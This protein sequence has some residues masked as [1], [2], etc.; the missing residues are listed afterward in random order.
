MPLIYNVTI[1]PAGKDDC[2]RITWNDAENNRINS[3][4]QVSEITIED[5]MR[6]SRMAKFQL[7]IGQK[8][9]RFLDG[10][11]HT[12]RRA[13]DRTH[14]KG[15]PLQLHLVTCRQTHDWPFELLAD[16]DFLLP[17]RVHLIRNVSSRG[18]ERHEVPQNRLLKLLFMASAALD[19][20][21][22]L[23]F[24][25]EEDAIF[26]ITANLPID[27]EVEDSGSLDGL[28]R[29]LVQEAFDVVHLS[30]HAGITKN[31][32]PYFLMEDETGDKHLVFPYKLWNEALIENPPKVLF[33]SGRCTIGNGN[34]PEGTETLSIARSLVKN[35]NISAVVGWGRAV[36]DEQA[37]Q[38]G[39]VIFYQLSRGK[40]ILEAVQRARYELIT[41]FP[42]MEK[43]AWP[44]LRLFSSGVP[45]NAIV[46]EGQKK[47]PKPKRMKHVYLKNSQV[48]VLT[49]GFVGRRRQL[50][51]ALRTL[52]QDAKKLGILILGT[53]GLGKSCLAGKICERFPHHILIIVH[54]KLNTLTLEPVLEYA[55]TEAQD[56]TGQHI[57][58]QK[59]EMTK[60]IAKLCSSSFK[61]K[62][63]L[64]LLDDFEQNLEGSEKNKPGSLWPEAAELLNALLRHL[65][66]GSTHTQL[67]ITSRYMFSLGPQYPV[68]IEV[69][70]QKVWLTGFRKAQQRK[71]ARALEHISNYPDQALVPRLLAAGHGNPRLMEWIDVLVGEMKD[72]EVKPLL[73]AVKDKQE[74]F[75]RQHLIRVLL[76]REEKELEL[77]LRRFSIFR[78]PV[79]LDG[80]RQVTQKG[81]SSNWEKRLQRGMDLSLIEHDQTR[82]SYQLTPL[83]RAELLPHRKDIAACHEAALAYYKEQSDEVVEL[84]RAMD[85]NDY[86]QITNQ[87]NSID[88]ITGE[89]LIYHA[90][91]CGQEDVAS[92]MGGVL[93]NHLG[94][95]IAAT[96]ALRIG[97][98]ILEEKK[99]ACCTGNDAF[100]LSTIAYIYSFFVDYHN[101]I[102]YSQQALPI[103][104]QVFGAKHP[105]VAISLNSLG[106]AYS[107][108]GKNQKA[109][110][111]YSEAL[112]IVGESN[113]KDRP[114]M[115]LLFN[116][117]GTAH[118]HLGQYRKAIHY[119]TQALRICKKFFT[120]DHNSILRILNNLGTA[121]NDLGDYVEAIDY[122]RQALIIS[123][124]LYDETHPN[125]STLLNNLGSIYIQ[126]GDYS[127]AVGYLE[128]ALAIDR[129]L[130]GESH[131]NVA[132]VLQNLGTCFNA[133]ADYPRA[134][135]YFEHALT[136]WKKAY[137][138]THPR[139]A[140]AMNNLGETWRSRG[141][142]KK[143]NEYLHRALQVDHAVHGENH[144]ST[145]STLSNLGSVCMT[146]GD[147][148]QA[149]LYYEKALNMWQDF[150]EENHPKI[151]TG[152]NNLGEAINSAGKH[153]QAIE[154]FQQALDILKISFGEEHPNIAG[155]LNNMGLAYKALGDHS[156]AI[157]YYQQ[158]FTL[159]EKHC[160]PKNPNTA[161]AVNNLGEA[162][163]VSG[164]PRKSIH[165]F[166]QAIDIWRAAYGENHPQVA[167][168]LNNL[169]L[170][171][172]S[173]GDYNKAIHSYQQA[174]DIL[175]AAYGETHPH[176]SLAL[177]SLA[178]A[179]NALNQH[180][181]KPRTQQEEVQ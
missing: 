126:L 66:P 53:G 10:E 167:T 142:H 59:E 44:M 83:L 62:N 55:F 70:L 131:P 151:A 177:N 56:D 40:S 85:N 4:E 104:R 81:H 164:E 155:T 175:R 140:A 60:K 46:K 8:L 97:L 98:W 51:R 61:E 13:L 113:S 27:M 58:S 21:P 136:I 180:A 125:I 106:M 143:A 6:L 3:F 128:Q 50:Q 19:V 77:F 116:N 76:E 174:I 168:P 37:L 111:Y 114:E 1:E 179:R 133:L 103:F 12:F 148:S 118:N 144:P 147:Y 71:K 178:E 176:L 89:E 153:T 43:P 35:Y 29:Q 73:K 181:D 39:K 154:Y 162:W 163:R 64:I 79:Q 11:T 112:D 171:W 120:K 67:I 49:E 91:G 158:A 32:R 57:L 122:Y 63:Y 54:G 23:D 160:G 149:A 139:V 137:G 161:I 31:S 82:Q 108:Q 47:Q 138:P 92:G 110:F 80:V 146:S 2:F 48:K 119:F 52:K 132:R 134:G 24:E 129:N 124:K 150:Y 101:M 159:W 95:R 25:R 169:G 109:L 88:S 127:K 26:E 99:E 34:R 75:I 166:Q 145:A 87:L 18:K 100:L 78:R 15:E 156:K 30:G 152:L 45:L 170:V 42:T 105:N 28:R 17:A 165:Y 102:H 33:L 38:A 9:Y 173:L 172:H 14:R 117:L 74:D 115:A 20:K 16:T 141:D 107:S 130:H 123:R 90:L 84:N 86:N 93:I 94:N 121:H 72:T 157:E 5:T 96:E 135:D 41:D 65:T 69:L 7:G 68:S 36:S 22:E